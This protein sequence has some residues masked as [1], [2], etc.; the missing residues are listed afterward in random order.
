MLDYQDLLRELPPEH[1]WGGEEVQTALKNMTGVKIDKLKEVEEIFDLHIDVFALRDLTSVEKKS[2][3]NNQK[4]AGTVVRLSDRP[5]D[6]AV[7]LLI[8]LDTDMPHYML[9][10]DPNELLK[11]L[12][13]PHC[14]AVLK[15]LQDYKKHVSKCEEGRA[16]HV[17]PGGFHK[18]PLGIREK[19]AS[20]GI[21]MPQDLAY[22]REFICYDFEAMFKNIS[23]QTEKTEYLRQHCPVSYVIC[24][25]LGETMS[26][27]QEDPKQLIVFFLRDLL[28][29]RKK[30]V[31]YM[32][33][34]FRGVFNEL[35]EIL[36]ESFEEVKYLEENDPCQTIDKE[37][38]PTDY[39]LAELQKKWVKEWYENIVQVK[40]DLVHYI[41]TVPV[42][43]YNSAHY[44][45]NLIKQHLITLLME[46]KKNESPAFLTEDNV[47]ED[48][49]PQDFEVNEGIK[50]PEYEAEVRDF[51]EVGVI[52]QSGSYT[53]LIVGK[54]LRFLDVYK[55]QSPNTSL[56][57]FMT[58]YK[59][60]VSK[61]VFPYEYLTPDTLYS[62]QIPEI[63]D[64]YS[65]LKGKNVLG[66]G[67]VDGRKNTKSL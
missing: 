19:L 2:K 10:T 64:F 60:P 51:S 23:V 18:Q 14:S 57:N 67:S 46:D 28:K 20:V 40:G 9:I 15:R 47:V 62:K 22:Y 50:Y 1:K 3:G 56:D 26:Q 32:T 58:T 41:K 48:L 34:D 63:K 61:G 53:Q 55:Y 33:E 31:Q 59:A 35:N 8:C 27:C 43:G 37:Q 17:Y 13:C 12:I 39:R 36:V 21:K 24:D 30:L 42:L 44:D 7:N 5:S 6:R 49:Y 16:R 4:T 45:I 29:L 54:K 52:K 11:K 65:S 25:S 66:D 38:N